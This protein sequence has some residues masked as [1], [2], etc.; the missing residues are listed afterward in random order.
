MG[1]SRLGKSVL[2]LGRFPKHGKERK[3]RHDSLTLLGLESGTSHRNSHFTAK[4]PPV[5]LPADVPRV[6]M[7]GESGN[8]GKS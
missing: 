2:G 6:Q 4:S 3:T 8:A 7:S 1:P 5:H